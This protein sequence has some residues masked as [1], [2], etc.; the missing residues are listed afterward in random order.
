MIA[1]ANFLGNSAGPLA[2]GAIAASVRINSVFAVTGTLLAAN[3]LWIWWRVPE[4]VR[5]GQ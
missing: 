2:G 1:S 3:F 4:I 5:G